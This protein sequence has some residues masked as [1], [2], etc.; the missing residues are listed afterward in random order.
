MQRV[1][2]I[3]GSEAALKLLG[4]SEETVAAWLQLV[5][6]C[7]VFALQRPPQ[8]AIANPPFAARK[9]GVLT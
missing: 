8:A 5:D 3:G 4:M 1:L 2:K 9:R 6:C 7:A